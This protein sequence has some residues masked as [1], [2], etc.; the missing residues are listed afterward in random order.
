MDSNTLNGAILNDSEKRMLKR[1]YFCAKAA[2]AVLGVF[3][4]LLALAI[5]ISL[6]NALFFE[7]RAPLVKGTATVMILEA[8]ILVLLTCTYGIPMIGTQT[9]KY[10]NLVEKVASYKRENNL[11]WV[12][13]GVA[14]QAVGRGMSHSDNGSIKWAGKAI[15]GIF[16]VLL[17]LQAFRILTALSEDIAEVMQNANVSRP[18]T[19]WCSLAIWITPILVLSLSVVPEFVDAYQSIEEE[20]RA[21]SVSWHALEDYFRKQGFAVRGEDPDDGGSGELGYSLYVQPYAEEIDQN[22]YVSINVARGG[23]VESVTYYVYLDVNKDKSENL[24]K[25]SDTLSMMNEQIGEATRIQNI[26]VTDPHLLEIQKPVLDSFAAQFES[27]S[28]YEPFT[29]KETD[30]SAEYYLSIDFRTSLDK[31]FPQHGSM[32]AVYFIS[33]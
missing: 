5:L 12:T 24:R 6:G 10:K 8:I 19:K 33:N 18:H 11:R 2:S 15:Q 14:G 23:A 22:T 3:L 29:V 20:K 28:Y 25:L 4:A 27:C 32:Q 16:S 31:E 26:R 30:K 9:K 7:S 21:A 1:F 17:F 13:V